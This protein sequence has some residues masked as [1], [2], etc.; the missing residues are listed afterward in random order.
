RRADA[1]QVPRPL[2]RA[3]RRVLSRRARPLAV[4]GAGRDRRD[5]AGEFPSRARIAGRAARP[6]MSAAMLELDGLVRVFDDVRAVDGVSFSVDRGQVLGFIGHNGAG[7]TTT[8]RIL[9]TLDTPQE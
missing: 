2:R 9:A 5:R 8:M 6:A 1:A 4:L 3:A 7:K